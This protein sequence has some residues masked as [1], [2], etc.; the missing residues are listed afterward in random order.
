MLNA[1]QHLVYR[2]LNPNPIPGQNC[3]C[4]THEDP[5]P[6]GSAERTRSYRYRN[7]SRRWKG[8]RRGQR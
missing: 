3:P 5:R 6:R 8:L 2:L 1:R 4:G 7:G